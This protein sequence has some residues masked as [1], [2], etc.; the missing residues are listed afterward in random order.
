MDEIKLLII[1]AGKGGVSLL[2]MFSTIENVNILAVID[3]NLNAPGI[4]LAREMDIP[5]GKDWKKFCLHHRPDI[6][7]NVTGDNMLRKQLEKY[8]GAQTE[9]IDGRS[10]YFMWMLIEKCK[11][12]QQYRKKYLAAKR[13]LEKYIRE[14]QFIIGKSPQIQAVKELILKVAPTPTTVL[15]RGETGT[16]KEM[17]ARAIHQASHLRDKP[18]VTV[19]CTALT[20]SL[21]ESELFGYKKGAFTGAEQDRKGLLEEADGG[22]VFLDEIGDMNL[23]LQAK[24]LRFLQTGEIRPVGSSKT[25]FVNVRIIAATNRELEKAIENKQFRSDL[26]YRFNTFTIFI[27]PLRD[28]ITDVPYL[29][30]HFLTKAEAKLNKRVKQIAGEALQLLSGYRWPGN[31]RE[32]ENVI[33]RAVIL[34]TGDTI[35]PEHLPLSMKDSEEKPENGSDF[36]AVKSKVLEKY[37]KHTLL[38][39]IDQANG[40]ISQ[41]SRLSGIPRRTFYRLMKKYG[42]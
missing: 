4:Q 37:E 39:Y 11:Q 38:K 5:V 12:M 25:I 31:V 20:P 28:R 36:K 18:F 6:I 8:K 2:Q 13:E 42:L 19:N 35:L 9:I 41:A 10:A 40:N 22:T 34:T 21:M 27:P 17:V 7:L 1:G 24:L 3:H 16:G 33:E 23:E 30:Y 15:L 26:F 32:L 29:A 14:D